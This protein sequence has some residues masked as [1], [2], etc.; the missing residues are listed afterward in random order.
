MSPTRQEYFMTL[1]KKGQ[2]AVE[3]ML[4]LGAV[5]VIVLVGFKSYLPSFQS[6]SNYYF[7]QVG[8]GILGDAN[9]C[10]DTI[11]SKFENSESCPPDCPSSS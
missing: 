5:M 1:N 10:G 3:Y 2:T 11:C 6:T 8:I 4:L 9:K 7:N